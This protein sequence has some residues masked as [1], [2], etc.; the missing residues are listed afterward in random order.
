MK[1]KLRYNTNLFGCIDKSYDNQSITNDSLLDSFNAQFGTN[2]TSVDDVFEVLVQNF[3]SYWLT[4]G[5]LV[6]LNASVSGGR[7]GMC[8]SNAMMAGSG[9]LADGRGCA[10]DSGVGKGILV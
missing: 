5:D 2:S 1:H 4:Y 7:I 9:L 8:S 10:S 3:S 6:M